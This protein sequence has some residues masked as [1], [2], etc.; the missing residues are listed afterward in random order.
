MRPI[1]APGV[2]DTARF[3]LAS[4]LSLTG[5][6]RLG[7][8]RA[9]G[10]A[11]PGQTTY[12]ALQVGGRSRTF[13]LHLP[14]AA[15]HDRVPLVLVFHGHH[16]N[17]AI[18]RS[19]SGLDTI[20]DRYGMAVAYPEGTGRLPGV[21]LAWN[22]VTCCGYAV[23]HAVD[24][25]GFAIALVDT[26]VQRG[27]IARPQVFAAG[28]SAGGMLALRLACAR[29]ERLMAVA[30]VAGAMPDTVCQ[31]ARPVSVLLIRGT[32]DDDLRFDHGKHAAQPNARSFSTSY[33]GAFAFWTEINGC[34]ETPWTTEG[35][36][37]HA[38][39][40]RRC[41]AGTSVELLTIAEHP[42][43]WPGG[44]RSWLLG[45]TPSARVHGS[46]LM[47]AFFARHLDAPR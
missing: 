4:V 32:D 26:L 27:W 42:H 35:A 44:E 18:A 17:G 16:S 30:N 24:D 31:P 34:R 25:V 43:A 46:A 5:C 14:P 29:A 38:R 1:W 13:L 20:A 23:T 7:G 39:L 41:Q 33:D 36:G 8:G 9:L 45:A 6:T 12:H 37:V 19:T 47:M 10:Y 3:L 11:F 15:A 21:G 28:F 22:A 2:R 40:A